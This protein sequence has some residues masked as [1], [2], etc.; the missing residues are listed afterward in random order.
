MKAVD[1]FNALALVAALATVGAAS[2][3]AVATS[4]NDVSTRHTYVVGGEVV[5][6]PPPVLHEATFP[7]DAGGQDGTRRGYVVGG[8]LVQVGR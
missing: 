2:A 4:D 6:P 5:H 1:S 3:L 8:K 7:P